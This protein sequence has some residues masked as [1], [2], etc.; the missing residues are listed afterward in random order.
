MLRSQRSQHG[1]KHAYLYLPNQGQMRRS[2]SVWHDLTSFS[3]KIKLVIFT[4]GLVGCGLIKFSFL[5]PCCISV[6]MSS[7]V[8]MCPCVSGGR[9]PGSGGDWCVE[10]RGRVPTALVQRRQQ[11]GNARLCL[12]THLGLVN[13]SEAR[14]CRT[15]QHVSAANTEL[16][17]FFR[18][19]GC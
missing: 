3:T 9:G 17:V 19:S 14:T 7:Y 4:S 5:T 15:L 10:D 6:F 18:W 1:I 12:C 11:H 2:E 8:L 13:S 16:M